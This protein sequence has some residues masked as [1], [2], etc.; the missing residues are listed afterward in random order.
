[1]ICLLRSLLLSAMIGL[2]LS[3]FAQ[4]Q[5]THKVKK[6]DTVYGIAHKYGISIDE[7]LAANPGV[8]DADFNIKKGTV[9]TIP[10]P[11]AKPSVQG[12]AAAKPAAARQADG[13]IN[14]GVLLP[15]HN[16]DGDGR[17]MVEYYR[18][19]LMSLDRLKQDGIATNVYAW[20]VAQGTS[21]S[22]LF[23]DANLQ[24]CNIIFG[25]LY[26]AQVKPLA[27]FCREHDIRMVIPFSISG[28]DVETN[29]EIFQVY[30]TADVLTKRA[31]DA[32]IDRFKGRHVV[33]IDC[34][35]STSR[36]GAFTAQLRQRLDGAGMKYSITNLKSSEQY[37][38]KAF[39]RTQGNVVVLNTGRSP[40]LNV[41]FAKLNSLRATD[42][43]VSVSMY[44]YTEWLMYTKVYLEL[45]HRYDTYIPSTF[46]Y[47]PL[48]SETAKVEN[49][50]RKWFRSD[51]QTALPRFALTGYDHGQ[52]FVRGYKK[53][54]KQFVGARWQNGYISLQN[55]LKFAQTGS[56]GGQQNTGFMLVHYRPGGGAETIS[57]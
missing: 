2:S 22:T 44:G 40:E 26:S 20:N 53:Y 28:N 13:P 31:V 9:L 46:F 18:G 33:F 34:N 36:K 38:S 45:F 12:T 5:T 19:L 7:L 54:G 24:R 6:N 35:D 43:T 37:F 11:A 4:T 39:S 16:N 41:A 10:S 8:A 1:M 48:N 55:Q 3:A 29:P 42:A 15:L 30:Q 51:M 47:N 14:I 49:E 57:Y 27:A 56:K 23:A 25:P 50:Y 21:V 32:F 52:F 17:R